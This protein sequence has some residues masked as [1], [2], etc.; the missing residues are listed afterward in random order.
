MTALA[1]THAAHRPARF[2]ASVQHRRSMMAKINIA[3][4][5]LAMDEDDYRQ[6]LFDTTGRTSLRDCS[7]AQLARM[8]D[9]LKSKGFQ[10]LP[11][12]KAAAH[13][14]AL[15]ARAL[16]IS[17]HHLG[18][19]HN[20]SEQA[21]E[22][23]AKRQLGCEKLVW[24]RQSDAFKLIEA[25]KAMGKRAGWLMQDLARQQPLSPLGLQ[26]SL[27]DAILTRLKACAAIPDNWALH[28]LSLIH[29]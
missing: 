22:A 26:A 10:P 6:G 27:C 13:P 24:A 17:L 16:W 1:A 15:K 28:D 5:Q 21:L 25:L 7:D 19:V 20:A 3:R 2:D 8:L 14:M 9:W 23:F 29:I 4:Q 12:R 11:G 18:V